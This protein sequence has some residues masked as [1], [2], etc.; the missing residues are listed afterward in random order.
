MGASYVR[1]WGSPTFRR[2][3]V[4]FIVAII[5]DAN[6]THLRDIIDTLDRTS[7]EIFQDRKAEFEENRSLD[8][9]NIMDILRTFLR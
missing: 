3:V 5:P 6:L 7:Q 8:G 1:Q 2:S 4:D 9:S